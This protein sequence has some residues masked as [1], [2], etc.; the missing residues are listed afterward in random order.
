MRKERLKI[1]KKTDQGKRKDGA[2]ILIVKH[3]FRWKHIFPHRDLAI[4][5]MLTDIQK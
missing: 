2:A 5:M 4:E 1:K 3:D